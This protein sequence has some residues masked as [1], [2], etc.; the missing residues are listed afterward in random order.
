VRVPEPIDAWW[1]RRR[2]STGRDVPYLVGTYREDWHRYPVLVR[3]YHS[4]LNRGIVLSQVPLSADVWLQWQCDAGHRFIATPEEQ[5]MRP[6]GGRRRRSTWCPRCAE[7]ALERPV[8]TGAPKPRRKAK[9]LCLK[10]PDLPPG[11]AFVSVCAPRAASAA[12]PALQQRLAK[13]LVW[14]ATPNAIRLKEPFFDHLEAWPDLVLADLRIAVE[15]D[16][17]GRYGLEHSG[18]REAVDLRK[19]R[20]IRRVGWEVVRVRLDPL[21]PIGPFDLTAA[22]VSNTLADRL[23]DRFREIRGALFVDAYL[24]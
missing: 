6:G 22:S 18:Q 15:L 1:E 3:Q 10:T 17:V 9:P 7:A 21:P 2:A 20:L 24:R 23:V 19:D 16:T 12:E 4:D 13:R 14:D 8:G 11:E 5:R